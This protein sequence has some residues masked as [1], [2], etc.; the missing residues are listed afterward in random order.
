M[1]SVSIV[2][3]ISFFMG[4][5]Y[6]SPQ[7]MTEFSDDVVTLLVASKS[8]GTQA[9]R[10]VFMSSKEDKDLFKVGRLFWIFP[11][12]VIYNDGEVLSLISFI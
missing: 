11:Y 7:M 4:I 1:K 3:L 2:S 8:R 12:S 6:L 10:A 9:V 5:L